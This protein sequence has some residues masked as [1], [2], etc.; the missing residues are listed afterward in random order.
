[1]GWPPLLGGVANLVTA[2]QPDSG[3]ITTNVIA[4]NAYVENKVLGGS[5][6]GMWL[7]I[8]PGLLIVMIPG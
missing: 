8:Q 2:S 4:L 3:S 7:R 1:M 6:T 5:E